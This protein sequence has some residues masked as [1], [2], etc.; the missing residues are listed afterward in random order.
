MVHMRP[1]NNFEDITEDLFN[2]RET[3]KNQYKMDL[4]K[5]MEDIKSRK[6]QAK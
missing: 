6:E 1:S 3:E 5:Q 4:Q 2:Y